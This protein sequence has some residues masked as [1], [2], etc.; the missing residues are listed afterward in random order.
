MR[1]LALALGDSS[2][3]GGTQPAASPS[4]LISLPSVSSRT[5]HNTCPEFSATDAASSP[6]PAPTR[7]R[8]RH[9]RCVVR[10]PPVQ[11]KQNVTNAG[12]EIGGKSQPGEQK[13][14]PAQF[15]LAENHSLGIRGK[16]HNLLS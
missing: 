8:E 2:H 1:E 4:H 10:G 3:C 9:A 13:R 6:S 12:A 7:A 16:Y 15:A 5:N 14:C 11:K